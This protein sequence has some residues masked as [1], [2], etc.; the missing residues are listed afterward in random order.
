MPG[1]PA[2][3]DLKEFSEQAAHYAP[4]VAAAFTVLLVGFLFTRAVRGA[5][6]LALRRTRIRPSTGELVVRIAGGVGWAFVLSIVFSTLQLQTLVLGISGVLALMGAAVV[7]SASATSNDIIA[8]FLLAADRDIEIGYRIQA[9][10]V[11]GVVHQIDFRKIRI[12]DDDGHL[13]VIPNRL[14]EG[15]EWIVLER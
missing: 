11:Q 13:H 8:G 12:V 5:V 3:L 15:A 9:A 4:K 7:S 1:G 14:V 10:G 2:V 6:R